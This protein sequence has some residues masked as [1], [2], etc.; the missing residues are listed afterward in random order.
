VVGV[1]ELELGVEVRVG[2]AD[3]PWPSEAQPPTAIAVAAAIAR[4]EKCRAY[5]MA[6]S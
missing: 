5:V 3:E 2:V 1:G 6:E 4:S